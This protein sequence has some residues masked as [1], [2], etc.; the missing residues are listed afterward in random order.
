MRNRV[1]LLQHMACWTL[2]VASTLV[3]GADFTGRV[4]QVQDGDTMTIEVDHKPVT[5]RLADIDAPD[6]RQAFGKRARTSLEAICLNQDVRV[7]ETG[8]DSAGHPIGRVQCVGTDASREQVHRGMAWVA[9]QDV[10][11]SNLYRL[12]DVARNTRKGLWADPNPVP[13]WE[14]QPPKKKAGSR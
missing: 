5:V 1:L 14:W 12:Q 7:R 3:R 6:L 10:G 11:D 8:K 13:P 4:T 2:L 9:P